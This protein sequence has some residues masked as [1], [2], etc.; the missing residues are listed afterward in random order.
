M[1]RMR[2]GQETP[3]CFRCPVCKDKPRVLIGDATASTIQAR[4]YAGTP[5]T[6]T[7]P[8]LGVVARGQ[9]QVRNRRSFVDATLPSKERV[10]CMQLLDGLAALVRGAGGQA[11][12]WGRAGAGGRGRGRGGRGRGRTGGRV[13][14]TGASG[15][16]AFGADDVERLVQLTEAFGAAP[17]VRASYECAPSTP[18]GAKACKDIAALLASMAT[19]SPVLSY[20][21]RRCAVALGEC[22]GSGAVLGSE[23]WVA[24]QRHAPVV[25][26]AL[27]ALHGAPGLVTPSCVEGLLKTLCSRAALCCE[28]PGVPPAA[29]GGAPSCLTDEC[30][31]TG[32]CCGVA[33]VRDRPQYATDCAGAE[34]DSSKSDCNHA[35][36][37]GGGRTGGVFTW[38][39]EHG[40]C[41]GFYMLHRAECRNEAFSFLT[42]YFMEAPQYV[43]YDFGCALQEYCLNRAPDFFKDTQFVVDRFHWLGHSSCSQGYNPSLYTMLQRVNTSI[44]EQ[45]NAVLGRVKGSI[46]RM[47]QVSFMLSVRFYLDAW[48]TKKIAL[49]KRCAEARASLPST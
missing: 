35:F 18:L 9:Q 33:K 47:A 48:N 1:Y 49:L 23:L 42:N 22:L 41:Y 20:L 45:C 13:G 11:S 12:S 29:D 37:G 32:I 44:A 3:Y 21:P 7:D 15:E 4:Y 40:I 24:L 34:G 17:F 2:R 43:V 36:H 30:L 10:E 31:L 28:G 6:K 16:A 25:H 46:T 8:A 19:E 39:C 38:F 14:Q 27:C 26:G 5:I